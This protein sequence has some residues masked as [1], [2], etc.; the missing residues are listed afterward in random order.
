MANKKLALDSESHLKLLIRLFKMEEMLI[1]EEYVKLGKKF[2]ILIN[3]VRYSEI[4]ES[5]KLMK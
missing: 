2:E 3:D 5:Y 4:I 1:K